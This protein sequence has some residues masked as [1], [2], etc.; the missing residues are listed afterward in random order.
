M[1]KKPSPFDQAQGSF[2]LYSGLQIEPKMV[3][4][5]E[6]ETQTAQDQ[7]GPRRCFALYIQNTKLEWV[8]RTF[9]QNYICQ[10]INALD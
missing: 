2:S 3:T 4:K 6:A 1:A 9:P 8:N 5:C 10:R 7:N